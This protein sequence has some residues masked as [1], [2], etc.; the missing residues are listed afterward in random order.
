MVVCVGY[1][2]ALTLLW[3]IFDCK[4]W[5]ADDDPNGQNDRQLK[6]HKLINFVGTS[7][8]VLG[9]III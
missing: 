7:N 3:H 1:T 6:L 4:T 2:D 9:S 8:L 5:L